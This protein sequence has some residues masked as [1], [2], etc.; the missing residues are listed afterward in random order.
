MTHTYYF[1]LSNDH[2]S[3]TRSVC[4]TKDIEAALQ[5]FEHVKV[6]IFI[7]KFLFQFMMK[8]CSYL[9]QSFLD[10]EQ[11]GSPELFLSEI[12]K[13]NTKEMQGSQTSLRVCLEACFNDVYFTRRAKDG[14]IYSLY[15]LRN[16]WFNL[17]VREDFADGTYGWELLMCMIEFLQRHMN[18]TLPGQTDL[19]N[20]Y[21]RLQS[22]DSEQAVS[23]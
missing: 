22:V 14:K 15:P 5:C 23:S 18:L 1:Q 13:S 16:G 19:L 20:E 9:L 12:Q 6:L 10:P 21:R 17:Y 7:E 11:R 3:D 4:E 2:N 8:Y